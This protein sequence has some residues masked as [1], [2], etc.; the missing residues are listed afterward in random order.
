M[1]QRNAAAEISCAFEGTHGRSVAL[2]LGEKEFRFHPGGGTMRA[3]EPGR[4]LVGS[5]APCG[6]KRLQEPA[7]QA[8]GR[9]GTASARSSLT[10]LAL[11]PCAEAPDV[12]HIVH[13]SPT[14]V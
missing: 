2:C 8:G 10:R 7:L 3:R 13:P 1:P 6:V 11:M 14:R 4:I 5:V 12:R 9:M